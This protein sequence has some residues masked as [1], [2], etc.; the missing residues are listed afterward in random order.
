MLKHCI[1]V[2]MALALSGFGAWAESVQVT[3]QTTQFSPGFAG[4]LER[5]VAAHR[6][7][8]GVSYKNLDTGEELSIN[9]DREFRTASTIKLAV[10]CAV[11]DEL[12]RPGGKFKGYY[13]T[14]RY[15]DAT[16]QGGSGFIQNYK[17]GTKIE[18][19]ELLYFMI[20]AS[21]NTATN[22]LVDWLGGLKPINDW[23]AAHGFTKTIMIAT[24]GARTVLDPELRRQWGIGRTTPDEMRRLM[25]MIRRGGAGTPA[26]T[27]EMMRILGHQYWDS[28][29][30][31]AIPP[32]TWVGSKS[33]ALDALRADNAIVSSPGGTY[34]LS[35][36]TDHNQDKRWMRANEG[37]AAIRAVSKAAYQHVNP[38]SNWSAP[39]GTEKF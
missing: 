9:G 24:I 18:L 16:S 20:T 37:D 30:A 5:I 21:D 6:G 14:M 15:D 25:E 29:I 32:W 19:K 33:G 28:G 4:E 36:Y 11:F 10:M 31:G 13:D 38:G 22:M 1:L 12:S 23:L 27:D 39:E 35:V 2:A 26:T 17:K 3:S 7:D 8:M 34:V